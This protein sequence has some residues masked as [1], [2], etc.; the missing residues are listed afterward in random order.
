VPVAPERTLVECPDRYIVALALPCPALPCRASPCRSAPLAAIATRKQ[1]HGICDRLITA[2]TL[3]LGHKK[4]A[5]SIRVREGPGNPPDK[6]NS[7]F[8]PNFDRL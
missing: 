1:T 2:L 7:S 4:A 3:P 8:I 5:H 6:M